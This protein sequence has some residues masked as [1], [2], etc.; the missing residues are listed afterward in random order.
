M[1]FSQLGLFL[2]PNILPLLM[3]SGAV[4]FGVH[5]TDIYVY[6]FNWHLRLGGE[7]RKNV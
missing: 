3:I 7:T 1:R 5:P 4:D 2:L 6:Y